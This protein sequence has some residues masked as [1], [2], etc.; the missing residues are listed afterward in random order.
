MHLLQQRRNKLYIS[1]RDQRVGAESGKSMT[2][3]TTQRDSL[4]QSGEGPTRPFITTCHQSL[5]LLE[6]AVQIRV[7]ISWRKADGALL[8]GMQP[9]ACGPEVPCLSL[10]SCLSLCS[11]AF[12]CV[13]FLSLSSSPVSA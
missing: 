13:C 5:S 2:G 4:A 6:L 12:L 9:G 3:L 11:S 1:R 7:R 10:L 8:A